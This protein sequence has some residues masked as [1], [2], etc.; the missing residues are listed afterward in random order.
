MLELYANRCCLSEADKPEGFQLTAEV[1]VVS[2]E[3]LI[4][5]GRWCEVTRCALNED[6]GGLGIQKHIKYS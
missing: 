3:V 2:L 5:R 4:S 1:C 6:L